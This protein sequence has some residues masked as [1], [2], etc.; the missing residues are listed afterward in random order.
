M[1]NIKTLSIVIPVYNEKATI[2]TVIRRVIEADLGDINKEII[3]VNDGSNDGTKEELAKIV[4]T[5]KVPIMVIDQVKNQGKS[6]ALRTGFEKVSGEV[7]VVQDGDLEY[8]P[9]DFKLMLKK[10]GEDGVRVVYGSRQL[11]GRKNQYS[12]LSFYLGGQVLTWITN[13]LYGANITDEPT[14]YKMFETKLLKSIKL[15]SVRFEFCPEVTAK[16]SRMGE[17]IYEVPIKYNPRNKKQGKKIKLSD[18]WEAVWVLVKNRARK[19]NE[20]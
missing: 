1:K 20:I 5:V 18:F 3:V 10:M 17:K 15:E 2:G 16:V 9:G 14:C 12:G 11:G 13:L 19:I 7:T 4:K 6:I 8:D